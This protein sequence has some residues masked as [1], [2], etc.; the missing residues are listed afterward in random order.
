[1]P[2]VESTFFNSTHFCRKIQAPLN[3]VFLCMKSL[4][5]RLATM[6]MILFTQ[7]RWGKTIK[8]KFLQ[9]TESG[10]Q[11]MQNDHIEFV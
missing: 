7:D 5:F 9:S 6:H 1:M 2:N 8:Q 4:E 11:K 10:P 3:L